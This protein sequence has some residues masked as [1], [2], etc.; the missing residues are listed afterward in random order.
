[1]KSKIAYLFTH[2]AP[3]TIYSDYRKIPE[4]AT[5]IGVD[6]G[7]NILES[8]QLYPDLIIGD[9]DSILPGVM[10]KYES[11]V[12]MITYPIAKDETDSELAVRW[13]IE[14]KYEEIILVNTLDGRFDH[15]MGLLQNMYYAKKHHI[16]VR[17]ESQS[18]QLFFLEK[19]EVIST[20]PGR[21]ISLLSYSPIVTM[22]RTKGLEYP[23][24]NENLYQ[25]ESRGISNICQEETVE[26]HY[27]EGDLLAIL[28]L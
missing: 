5:I 15:V 14:N 2:P 10:A 12:R 27:G 1:M 8:L 25:F 18:Q 20:K 24:D 21:N 3:N 9:M 22:V 26:I 4:N 23:L 19:D 28:T 17:I 7:T 16:K 13:C 11:K 6:G